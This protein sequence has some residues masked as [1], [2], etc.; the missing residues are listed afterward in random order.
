MRIEEYERAK[1]AQVTRS[2]S[3]IMV[4]V[5][6]LVVLLAFM[7]IGTVVS[8]VPQAEALRADHE[9]MMGELDQIGSDITAVSN[10]IADWEH[11]PI[12]TTIVSSTSI[13]G[14]SEANPD[15]WLVIITALECDGSYEGALGVATVILNRLESG[16]W[17][18]TIYDVISA[19]NQFSVYNSSRTPPVTETIRSACEDA[20]SGI[21]AFDSDVMYFCTPGAY[22]Q[23]EFFQSLVEV[24]RYAGTVWCKEA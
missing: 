24:D 19:H 23:S 12:E 16:R 18:D 1:L 14:T 4:V 7:L 2:A 21:R 15:G 13:M 9:R 3:M 6:I 10:Y 20:L 22:E 5:A 8:F 11:E 17:G